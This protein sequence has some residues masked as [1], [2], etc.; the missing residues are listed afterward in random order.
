MHPLIG[1]ALSIATVLI[2]WFQTHAF[3]EYVSLVYR[4]LPN[5]FK[6]FF[7]LEEFVKVQPSG[8][9]YV[10]FLAEYYKETFRARLMICPFCMAVWVSFVM[11]FFYGFNVF[12]PAIALG[13]FAYF[14]IAILIDQVK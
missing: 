3:S 5:W 4:W 7:I 12:L 9:N 6:R 2:I 1:S 11:S 14:S 13:L 8:I 10:E